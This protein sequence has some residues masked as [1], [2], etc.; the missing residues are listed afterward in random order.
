MKSPRTRAAVAHA[1]WSLAAIVV[2]PLLAA[3]PADG[4]DATDVAGQLI[5]TTSDVLDLLTYDVHT[6]FRRHDGSTVE[7]TT[8]AV[9][10]VPE[11]VDVNGGLPDVTV[12]ILPLLD[13]LR[14]SV[15][16]LPT[17]PTRLPLKVEAVIDVPTGDGP[18]LGVAYGYDQTEA[19][20]PRTF[21]TD[22]L[23]SIFRLPLLKNLSVIARTSGAPDAMTIIGTLFTRGAGRERV[24]PTFARLRVSP[25]P[26]QVRLDASVTSRPAR[27]ADAPDP[28]VT[29]RDEV[30]ARVRTNQSVDAVVTAS[31]VRGETRRDVV[32]DITGLPTDLT[33]GFVDELLEDTP[34]RLTRQRDIILS[35]SQTTKKVD[36]RVEELR[37][38]ALQRSIHAIGDEIPRSISASLRTDEKAGVADPTKPDAQTDTT[39]VAYDADGAVGSLSL[40]ADDFVDGSR[41][42]QVHAVAETLPPEFTFERIV[43]GID[44]PETEKK[45]STQRAVFDAPA[46]SLGSLE[47]G[48]A[49][50]AAVVFPDPAPFFRP[51]DLDPGEEPGYAIVD[52][53]DLALRLFGI[54]HALVD[55]ADPLLIEA[56]AT[57]GPFAARVVKGSLEVTGQV[58]DLPAAATV[59][60]SPGRDA[61][62]TAPATPTTVRYRGS[63]P[64]GEIRA[65]ATETD[66]DLTIFGEVT[67]AAVGVEDVPAD[68]D[69]SV[70][71]D[72]PNA[73]PTDGTPEVV[74]SFDAHGAKVGLLEVLL[75]SGPDLETFPAGVDGVLLR[76]VGDD[77]VL[78]GRLTGLRRATL[79][80]TVVLGDP[81][82]FRVQSSTTT[83]SLDAP[84]EG[85]LPLLIDL[86]QQNATGR[87]RTIVELADR[88]DTVSD[89]TLDQE[90][91]ALP[92]VVTPFL[93]SPIP[94]RTSL[95]YRASEDSGEL[96]VC[97][98]HGELPAGFDCSAQD[99]DRQIGVHGLTARI[100]SIPARLDVCFA[101]DPTELAR[102]KLVPR[103]DCLGTADAQPYS[104]RALCDDGD[105]VVFR[106]ECPDDDEL[107]ISM[108]LLVD[109]SSRVTVNLRNCEDAE[110]LEAGKACILESGAAF[111]RVRDLSLQ[112]LA[113]QIDKPILDG[114]ANDNGYAYLDTQ[115]DGGISLITGD[116]LLDPGEE[117]RVAATFPQHADPADEFHAEDRLV[118]FEVVPTAVNAIPP[119]LG[120]CTRGGAEIKVSIFNI[121]NDVCP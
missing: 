66:P 85:E 73:A 92:D 101:S 63:A 19:T 107:P 21:S 10:G 55:T 52:D 119:F 76:D 68:L 57:S 95:R 31:V 75:T 20:A 47:A 86:D 17:A 105:G 12:S 70:L 45:E 7:R 42:R 120:T 102:K 74:A 88:P 109:A 48:I 72:D 67:T 69:L 80:R 14:L 118:V 3:S 5:A 94:R 87:H 93:K 54:S 110:A 41:S 40:T 115:V 1:I 81:D 121:A 13:R 108:S 8:G 29:A 56:A 27:P 83:V 111:I 53:D 71:S 113:A 11:L 104:E 23:F 30:Q 61:T 50:G 26:P 91:A 112:R 33:V 22:L 100:D 59:R 65:V 15:T 114:E 62:E 43:R 78:G 89:L 97:L 82:R 25:V 18:G 28:A 90:Q 106:L 49:E 103:V 96:S 24:D 46:G 16:K 39:T 99:L 79:E 2:L 64:I 9:V 4:D 38:D 116:V 34:A 36:V 32:A 77:F 37:D 60:F 35:T 44:D 117:A 98:R 51:G 6:T 84:H 58:L